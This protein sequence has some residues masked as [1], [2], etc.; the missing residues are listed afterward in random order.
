MTL[1]K[2]LKINAEAR[3]VVPASA[4]DRIP[5]KTI[6]ARSALASNRDFC[7]KLPGG[8]PPGVASGGGCPFP[9]NKQMTVEG[10]FRK[11]K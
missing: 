6:R 11:R 4:L 1:V 7:R 2:V 10:T 8:P 5:M 3:G 9:E